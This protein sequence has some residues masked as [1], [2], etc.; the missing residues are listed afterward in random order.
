MVWQKSVFSS[1][2]ALGPHRDSDDATCFTSSGEK[3]PSSADNDHPS[4]SLDTLSVY[5][6]PDEKSFG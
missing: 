4:D 1:L 5:V 6:S 3:Q 2:V